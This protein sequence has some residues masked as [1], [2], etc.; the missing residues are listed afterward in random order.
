MHQIYRKGTR[1]LPTEYKKI[2][3]PAATL[4]GVIKTRRMAKHE[5]GGRNHRFPV[6]R[7][8][9]TKISAYKNIS[10]LKLYTENLENKTGILAL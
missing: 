8:F 9:F 3:K 1:I 2:K 5:H 7:Y 10:K 6:H 4:L